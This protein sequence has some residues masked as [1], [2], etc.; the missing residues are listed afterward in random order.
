MRN[1]RDVVISDFVQGG[2]Y[3]D[4]ASDYES[5]Y[6]IRSG[7][8]DAGINRPLVSLTVSVIC[9]DL[10]WS[11]ICCDDQE[12][13]REI[14]KS[15]NYKNSGTVIDLSDCPWVRKIRIEL[16]SNNGLTPPQACTLTANYSYW[17]M[18]DGH[19]VPG[20]APDL[21]EK[22]MTKPYPLGLWRIEDGKLRTGL[23]PDIEELGAF[24]HA[25]GLTKVSIPTTCKRIGEFAF[26]FTSLK[27]VKLP[28]DCEYYPTSFPEG[29]D[30]SGGILIDT[31]LEGG[32]T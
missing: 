23:M 14:S 16:H 1:T 18:T 10:Q 22:A 26:R 12:N 8:I 19:P 30:V 2:F 13:F 21:P 29:C 17:E 3:V 9:G 32:V 31:K 11:F 24:C 28:E 4:D 27:S 7:W 5:A 6:E 15:Y 20:D 25:S